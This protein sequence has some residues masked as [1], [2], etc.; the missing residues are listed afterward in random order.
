M[1]S[2]MVEGFTEVSQAKMASRKPG[3]GWPAR[4]WEAIHFC[5]TEK[6]DLLWSLYLGEDSCHWVQ[7]R[8]LSAKHHRSRLGEA[9]QNPEDSIF[10][11]QCL[12]STLYWQCLALCQVSK[13]TCLQGPAPSVPE[14][15]KEGFRAERQNMDDWHTYQND[16][17]DTA[18]I[19][20]AYIITFSVKHFSHLFSTCF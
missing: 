9:H 20:Q 2:W 8:E 18:S 6:W 15:G 14:Q 5:A 12:S 4:L 10:L 7:C 11:G 16:L 19:K 17:N 1:I 3:T 13:E